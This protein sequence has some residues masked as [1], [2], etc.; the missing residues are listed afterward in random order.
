MVGQSRFTNWTKHPTE[1]LANVFHFWRIKKT[2]VPK[3]QLSE[4]L[5]SEMGTHGIKTKKGKQKI[6]KSVLNIL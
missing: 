5:R 1:P 2:I 3:F 6:K 4:C